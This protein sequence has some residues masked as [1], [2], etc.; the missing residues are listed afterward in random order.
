[1]V[2]KKKTDSGIITATTSS[3]LPLSKQTRKKQ[4]NNKSNNNRVI[5]ELLQNFKL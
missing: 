3:N 2:V 4:T 5:K 1:M